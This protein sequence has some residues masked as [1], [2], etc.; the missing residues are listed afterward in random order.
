M[1]KGLYIFSLLV[2]RISQKMREIFARHGLGLKIEANLQVTDFL[3]V[4][5]DLKQGTHRAWVKPE[6]IIH[7]VNRESN[8]PAH[9]LKN[10]PLE[11]QRRLTTLSSSQAMF[12]AAKGPFQD[13]LQRAG[14]DHHLIYSPTS[15]PARRRRR[16]RRDILWFNPPFCKSVKSNIGRQFLQL[17]DRCFPR[18]HPLH[19]VL[20]RHTVQ[21]SYRTMPNLGKIVA[22]HNTKVASPTTNLGEKNCNCRGRNAIC[23]MEGSRCMDREVV[24]QAEVAAPTKA[25]M[26]YVGV[27]APDWKS[28]Y[29]NHKTDFKY[30]EKRKHTKLAGYIWSLKDEGILHDDINIKWRILAHRPSFKASNNTCRLCLHEKY[31]LMHKPEEATINARDEFFSGCLHKHSLLL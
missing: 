22:G 15:S 1:W 31:I 18:G 6:Q 8:H 9:V 12:E 5:L 21:L 4:L 25:T 20:N 24:Y 26:K 30:T 23:V 14:Y 13:A 27:C 17:L 10:I 29:R 7:Y 28:R 11:V 16:R 2:E 19:K 3:D